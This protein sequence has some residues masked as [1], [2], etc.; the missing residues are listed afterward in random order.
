MPHIVKKT[1][2]LQAERLAWVVGLTASFAWGTASLM[3]R[4]AARE[5]IAR[6]T[7]L[8]AQTPALPATPDFQ[9]WSPGR[10][11]AWHASQSTPSPP[12]MGVLRIARLHV[13]AAI[14]EGIDEST[15]N[16][17]VGHIPG[18]AGP[19]E[20]GNAGIAGH[21]DSFFRGLKNVAIGDR[22][23]L[24]L[25]RGE[26]VYRVERTWIVTPDDVWVL[27]PTPSA[28]VT[29]VTCYPFHFVGSAPQRFI[30]RAVPAAKSGAERD[31]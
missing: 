22:I 27:A 29:L 9:L 16:R 5:E 20:A 26:V 4:A 7:T 1:L 19:G 6:F 13:E 17:A 15:L 18:T 23:E 14:L 2:W 10:I 24:A 12:P 3:D 30:V 28:V 11:Q 21:R 8:H 25:P 31:Q